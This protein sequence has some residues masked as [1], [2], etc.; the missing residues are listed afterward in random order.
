MLWFLKLTSLTEGTVKCLKVQ[1]MLA[2]HPTKITPYFAQVCKSLQWKYCCLLRFNF[3][4]CNMSFHCCR[5]TL[6]SKINFTHYFRQKSRGRNDLD[7]SSWKWSTF[8]KKKKDKI[9]TKNKRTAITKNNNNNNQVH[10]MS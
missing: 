8:P 9:K 6:V 2:K 4:L 1:V 3:F 7:Q 5:L 10:I